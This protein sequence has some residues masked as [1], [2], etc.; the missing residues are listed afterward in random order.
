[1]V[2]RNP[3]AAYVDE[4]RRKW[5]IA[6]GLPVDDPRDVEAAILEEAIRND[7]SLFDRTLGRGIVAVGRG[8]LGVGRFANE[9]AQPVVRQ[10]TDPFTRNPEALAEILS[11]PTIKMSLETADAASKTGGGLM[12]GA[13]APVVSGTS[14]GL[15]PNSFDAYIQNLEAENTKQDI[16]GALTLQGTR[17]AFRQTKFPPG[18]AGTLEAAGD[19][20]NLLPI[21]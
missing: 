9:Q 8:A 18:V 19:V 3:F 13:I 10:I 15:D 17:D 2:T 12:A 14:Y 20:T 7:P 21:H 6:N 5:R 4:E 11:D 1:M 16:T